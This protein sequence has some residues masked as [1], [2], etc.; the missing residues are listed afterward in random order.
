MSYESRG[1]KIGGIDGVEG[2]INSPTSWGSPYSK[3]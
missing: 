3:K 1:F 2:K